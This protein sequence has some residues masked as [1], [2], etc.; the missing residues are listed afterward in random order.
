MKRQEIKMASKESTSIVSKNQHDVNSDSKQYVNQFITDKVI[1]KKTELHSVF[2]N[3]INNKCVSDDLNVNNNSVITSLSSGTPTELTLASSTTRLFA[4]QR[5]DTGFINSSHCNSQYNYNHS[6][7]G[8]PDQAAGT[9]NLALM[10]RFDS[11]SRNIMSGNRNVKDANISTS[12]SRANAASTDSDELSCGREPVKSTRD[13]INIHVDTTFD[14]PMPDNIPGGEI[15]GAKLI[16]NECGNVLSKTP[17]LGESPHSSGNNILTSPRSPDYPSRVPANPL[18]PDTTFIATDNAVIRAPVSM[19]TAKYPVNDNESSI[20]KTTDQSSVDAELDI[21]IN[22][23]LPIKI[24][25]EIKTE[26]PDISI[27]IDDKSVKIKVD[28]TCPSV[29]E[30]SRP[31]VSSSPTSTTTAE[32]TSTSNEKRSRDYNGSSDRHR[33]SRCYKRSKIKR[34]S[35]GVQ[36]RRDRSAPLQ[37][38]RGTGKESASQLTNPANVNLRLHLETKSYKLLSQS[39]AVIK[40]SEQLEGLKYRRFI[41]IEPYPNGGATVVHMYQDEID[42]LPKEQMDELTQEFFKVVFGE[43]DNGNAYHVMGIVHNSAAYLPDLLDHM[44]YNYPTLTVKNGVLGRNSDIETTTM[45]QYKEQVYK[46]YNNGTVR[47]GPLHQISL[48]GTVHEEVGGYFPDLLRRLEE[49]PFLRLTMPWGAM[50]VVQ[51]ETPQESND[52]P[53]LW[54]RPGEQLVPTADI[55]KSPCKRR[56]T[57]INELRNLQ[58]LPRLSEA[59]EYMFE[60]R[61]RAHADH[62]GHGLD[63]MTTAAVGVL[64]AI[65]GGQPSEYNRITKDVVAFYA[66]D[67]PELVEKLQLDLHEPP[68]SQCVQWIE[69]AKLN[70]LRRQGIRYAR[71]NL[72]DNDIY[73]LPRNIIH[74]FRTVSAVSS[75]AWHVRLRQYY[76]DAAVNA[77]TRHGRT[78]PENSNHF[79]EK[80]LSGVLVDEQ[81]ENADRQ[82]M[83]E[84]KAK[85]RAAEYQGNLKKSEH[86]RK[87]KDDRDKSRDRRQQDSRCKRKERRSS[88]SKLDK[89]KGD[90]TGKRKSSDDDRRSSKKHEDRHRRRRSLSKSRRRSSSVSHSS[91]SDKKKKEERSSSNTLVVKREEPNQVKPC[92]TEQQQVNVVENQDNILPVERCSECAE[93]LPVRLDD[94]TVG[95]RQLAGKVYAT[96]VVDKALEIAVYKSKTDVDEV[97]QSLRDGVAEA[98]KEVLEKIK[99]ECYELAVKTYEE[100]NSKFEEL[101]RLLETETIGAFTSEME[102]ATENAVKALIEMAEEEAKERAKDAAE[103]TQPMAVETPVVEEPKEVSV[104]PVAS[105][106]WSHRESPKSPKEHRSSK[107]SESSRKYKDRDSRDR[108]KERRDRDRRDRDKDREHKRKSPSKSDHRDTESNKPHAT[109]SSSSPSSSSSSST[110]PSKDE[111]RSSSS[112]DKTKRDSHRNEKDY[113]R[114]SSSSSSHRD[115]SKRS[116]TSSSSY[117]RKATSSSSSSQV[118]KDSKRICTESISQTSS[119]TS[120]TISNTNINI[121]TSTSTCS[122]TL[123][124]STTLSL[125]SSLTNE[126]TPSASA[127]GSCSGG[128]DVGSNAT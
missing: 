21:K 58:Y 37:P 70:Q 67:F 124:S 120:T 106:E 3:D 84:K 90:I 93:D 112:S 17:Q 15:T 43:D 73:F 30:P 95:A 102:C 86:G 13:I 26:P 109:S 108:H 80:D 53:I 39:P 45:L 8:D 115:E 103:V 87:R 94:E 51:M 101:W 97:C 79:K 128:G 127:S 41:H 85:E 82:H 74:Q 64:K 118:H 11:S 20:K 125:S 121:G 83:A 75:I 55:N 88:T 52:G 34:A 68:I 105:A 113:H 78:I 110:K 42:G 31:P 6:V 123:L 98:S 1:F 35:I 22:E 2:I 57:G 50:S 54:I 76:P 28:S 56:R 32:K 23:S 111:P 119:N 5:N 104:A 59:R 48:V 60:D 126:Q 4:S 25:S 62:V 10:P 12:L 81:K 77:I 116:S 61:T 65:H 91:S 114:K 47:Y 46:A 92:L 18:S 89:S 49:N 29:N 122:S 63:R 69:D 66:G 38:Q 96:E 16:E 7:D 27:G 99:K 24:E 36:C 107:S 33:C 117:K 40:Y 19:D 9:V 14:E 44:A 71:I 100:K 72:Y